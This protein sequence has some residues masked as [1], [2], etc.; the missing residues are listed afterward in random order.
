MSNNILLNIYNITTFNKFIDILDNLECESNEI[1]IE[2][3]KEYLN[4]YKIIIYND[5][6]LS[7][8][9]KILF[10]IF[11]Y[12]FIKIFINYNYNIDKIINDINNEN[13][14]YKNE[15]Q[16]L[17]KIINNNFRKEDLNIF[18]KYKFENF[19]IIEL[20]YF[21]N[22]LNNL[23]SFEQITFI[24]EN[25]NKL[26]TKYNSNIKLLYNNLIINFN[27]FFKNL[28]PKIIFDNIIL[29]LS[30]NDEKTFNFFLLYDTIN[31]IMNNII[32][33]FYFLYFI[34]FKFY[35]I[36]IFSKFILNFNLINNF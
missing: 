21:F 24:I 2:L 17:N 5:I 29:Y 36:F 22:I 6:I 32:N 16:I 14:K 18:I 26:K 23:F 13:F 10:H 34:L 1:I 4:Q 28:N 3:F 19:N 15:K 12:N 35:F 20:Q 11:S 8:L 7:N 27:I 30:N 33:S 9:K 31:Y 25:L